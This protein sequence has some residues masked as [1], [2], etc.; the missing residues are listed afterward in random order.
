MKKV[1]LVILM[2]V[3]VCL[4]CVAKVDIKF[5]PSNDCE[6]LIVRY[7]EDA[8]K[9][10]DIAVYS[11]SN[12][13]IVMALKR[14]HNRRVQLRILTDKLQA[15]GR[16]SKVIEL[17]RYGINIRVNSKHKIEHNKFA[18]YDRK[19]ASTG[20]F[21]WTKHASDKNSENCVFLVQDKEAVEKYGQRFE[22]L[23]R[24]NTKQKSDIWFRNIIKRKKVLTN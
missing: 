8:Q 2:G 23:W 10:I 7:I 4:P 21:N 18:V 12:E 17:Y 20:S 15:S 22:Q 24:L 19:A 3:L 9:S 5:T 1:L 14:A 13:K 16:S 6:D 11:I